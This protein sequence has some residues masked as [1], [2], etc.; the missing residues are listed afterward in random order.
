MQE[1]VQLPISAIEPSPW[2]SRLVHQDIAELADS[3]RGDGETEGVGVV[4]P[5][6]VRRTSRGRYQL[7]DGERRWRAAQLIA[8]ERGDDEFLVPA[9]IFDVTDRVAQLVGAAA[10]GE[11]DRRKPLEMALLYHHLREALEKETGSKVG[12]RTIAGIGWHKR[13]MVRDYLAVGRVITPAVLRAAGIVDEHGA[14]DESVVVKLSLNELLNVARA[15]NARARVV[16]LRAKANHIRGVQPAADDPAAAAALVSCEERLAQFRDHGGLHIRVRGPVRTLPPDAASQLVSHELAP[17]MLA[18]V[19]QAEGG[20]GAH[21]YYA[22]FAD[23]RTVL[24]VPREVEA[25]SA[26]Q[27]EELA[28]HVD[29]LR[30]RI[31][32]AVRFRRG[33]RAEREHEQI[34]QD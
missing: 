8:R 29:G 28:A 12:I 30:T 19:D 15:P 14:A 9:R 1:Y 7:L 26:R 34:A 31:W 2:Q 25:L 6:L 10:E 16:A 20:A 11:T 4:E 23:R 5:L 3:I 24:V 13:S 32:R 22:E 27:L 21:G 18:A 33:V 17:A